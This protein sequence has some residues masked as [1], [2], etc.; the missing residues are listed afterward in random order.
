MNVPFGSMI[1][2]MNEKLKKVFKVKESN[3]HLNYYLCGGVAGALAAI[4]TTP[5]D[6]IKTKLNTQTCLTHGCEKRVACEKMT[7]K[8]EKMAP[9][10]SSQFQKLQPNLLNKPVQTIF[11][12]KANPIKYH[13]ILDTTQTIFRE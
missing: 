11:T 5:F 4:P 7:Q 12:L 13:N 2:L 10:A 1:I 9:H 6:V 3:N 8:I